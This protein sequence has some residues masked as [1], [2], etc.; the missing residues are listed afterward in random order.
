MLGRIARF[1][2]LEQFSLECLH[3]SVLV[4]GEAVETDVEVHP[5]LN[6]ET[7]P[8]SSSID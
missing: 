3:P 2:R 8:S 6:M 7:H 5:L 1:R 4:V